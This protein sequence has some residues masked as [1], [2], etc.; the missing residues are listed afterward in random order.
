MN[1]VDPMEVLQ[2]K[3]AVLRQTGNSYYEE[4]KFKER[5]GQYADA[6]VLYNK[7][8]G[9]CFNL[10]MIELFRKSKSIPSESDA[11]YI[12]GYNS[13][14]ATLQHNIENCIN[15]DLEQSVG[16]LVVKED[17]LCPTSE[18]VAA[19]GHISRRAK[20]VSIL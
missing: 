13:T 1:A 19:V 4:A 11:D 3:I 5:Q 2:Y 18:S 16:K 20:M 12:R 9:C 15:K 8:Y 14:L 6:A 7:V 10:K 17:Q